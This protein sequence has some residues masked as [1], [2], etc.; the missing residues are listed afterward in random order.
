MYRRERDVRDTG[1]HCRAGEQ[2]G[3]DGHCV[4]DS[5]NSRAVEAIPAFTNEDRSLLEEG[6]D[7]RDAHEAKEG[8]R[9]EVDG[10]SILNLV[11]RCAESDPD[12]GEE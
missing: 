3:K 6:R 8:D 2:K 5:P 9:K 11:R 10:E 12:C 7:S 4:C 1:E